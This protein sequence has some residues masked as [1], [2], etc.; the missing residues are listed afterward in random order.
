MSKMTKD[1]FIVTRVN[2]KTLV[3]QQI[4]NTWV[5]FAMAMAD[6]K[7]RRKDA[8]NNGWILQCR[9]EQGFKNVPVLFDK[10]TKQII[11]KIK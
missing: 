5:T 8:I 1:S 11:N 7:K 2:I 6:A 10:Q 3:A 4:S 9:S